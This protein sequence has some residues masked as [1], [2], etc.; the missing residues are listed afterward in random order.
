MD[1]QNQTPD[2]VP[3]IPADHGLTP[4]SE[5]SPVGSGPLSYDPAPPS[6]TGGWQP[7]PPSGSEPPM[8]ASSDPGGPRLGSPFSRR[9]TA[10]LAGLVVVAAVGFGGYELGSGK[11]VPTASSVATSPIPSPS[12]SSTASSSSGSSK[13]SVS[14]VAAKVDPGVVDITADDSDQGDTSAGTGM[15][16]TSNGEVLTNNHVIAGATKIT[17]QVDGSGTKYS[18]KV[19]GTDV[20]QDVALLQLENA[21]GMSTVTVGN[22]ADVKVGDAVVAI[23]NALDLP[24]PPTVTDGIISAL[25]R[26]ITASD[27][28]SSASENL[29]GLFQTDAPLSSGNSGGPLANASGPVI[30]MDTAAATGNSDGDSASNVGFAIPIN[31]ALSIASSI[32]KGQSSSL[33]EIGQSAFLGVDVENVSNAQNE[34]SG[35]TPPTSSGA[36]V[37]EV[38]P[39]SPAASVGLTS[40]D[41]ITSLGGKSIGSVSALTTALDADQPGQSVSLGWV[42]SADSSESA[43]VTLGSGPAK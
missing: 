22:S 17:A 40:G 31:E 11:P 1:E 9:V 2:Q 5:G 16:L 27:S 41:V 30:G 13:I 6:A 25:D 42:T 28:G 36:L 32:Q 26:S 15:V 3:E 19:V 34:Y 12:A 18:A 8:A 10:G 29:K 39:G 43:T 37:V 21:S 23:G 7:P 38:V 33:I 4:G 24:G 35:Y 20:T 14:D